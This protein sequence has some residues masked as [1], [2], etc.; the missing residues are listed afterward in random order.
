MTRIAIVGSR[1][2]PLLG[3]VELF[4]KTLD[5]TTMIVSG[6]AR[7]VDRTAERAAKHRGLRA[8]IFPAD[9]PTYGKRA[10]YIRNE[11][12]VDNADEIVVF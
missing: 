7:G 11:Q 3:S 12:I 1:D 9:W 10:G 6:G 4:V 5:S 2:Y 8:L